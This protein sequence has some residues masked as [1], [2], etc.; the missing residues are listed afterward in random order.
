MAFW[1][2]ATLELEEFRPGIMSRAE[3]GDDLIMVCMEIAPGKEDSGHKHVFDQCGIIL[4]GQME[5]FIGKERKILKPGQ[6]FFIPSGEHHGWK[7]FDSPVKV[8]DISPTQ[9]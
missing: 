6:A 5:L 9:T 7:T 2:L 4:E 1:N 3:I 8:M